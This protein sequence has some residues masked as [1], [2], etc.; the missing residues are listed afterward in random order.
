MDANV[1]LADF[2][3]LK[4]ACREMESKKIL[5]GIVGNADSEVIKIAHT[6]EYGTG[7]HPERSFIRA[8]FDADQSVLE[9]II[10]A[11]LTRVLSG[12]TDPAAAAHSIGA[13][14]AQLVQNFIDENRVTPPSDFSRKTQHT[15]LFETGTHIRDRIAYKVVDK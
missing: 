10:A 3:R 14:A 11:Q 15:T 7:S 13:Q 12:Q 9:Q 1:I 2:G 6:H 4:S 8:S 5:I